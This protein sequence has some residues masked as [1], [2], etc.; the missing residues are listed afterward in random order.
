MY[1]PQMPQMAQAYQSPPQTV[2]ENLDPME[3]RGFFFMFSIMAIAL[4]AVAGLYG[5]QRFH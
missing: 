5:Y 3:N 2:M 4:V 1:Y